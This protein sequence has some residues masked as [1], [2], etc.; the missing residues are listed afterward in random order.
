MKQLTWASNLKTVQKNMPPFPIPLYIPQ[1]AWREV[2][3]TI[4]THYFIV[5]V[6]SSH[7]FHLS[8]QNQILLLLKTMSTISTYYHT[9]LNFLFLPIP[10]LIFLLCPLYNIEYTAAVLLHSLSTDVTLHILSI[11][12]VTF[13]SALQLLSTFSF[14]F[15]STISFPLI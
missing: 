15:Q 1:F 6:N 12:I 2:F 7:S 8:L 11:T 3:L 4:W 5:F 14:H 9:L 13:T 10:P